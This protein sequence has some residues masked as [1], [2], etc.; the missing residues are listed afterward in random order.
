MRSIFP[1]NTTI[2]PFSSR[3][4]R[5]IWFHHFRGEEGEGPTFSEDGFHVLAVELEGGVGR[6]EGGHKVLD[7][8]GHPSFSNVQGRL[9][10]VQ[11]QCLFQGNNGAGEIA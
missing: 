5:V 1:R 4:F 11:L 3:F 8:Q 2:P 9:L 6:F 7:R 10:L